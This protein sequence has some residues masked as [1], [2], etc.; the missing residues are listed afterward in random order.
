MHRL[1]LLV[2]ASV[3]HAQQAAPTIQLSPGDSTAI[4]SKVEQ[5]DAAVRAARSK[6]VSEDLIADVDVY[7][8]A[9]KWVLE[10]PE[11]LFV[12][13]DVKHTLAV[14]DTGIERAHELES[15]KSPWAEKKRKRVHGYYSALDGSVQPYAVTIPE[16]YDGTGMLNARSI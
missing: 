12:A 9:G 7:A 13:D 3:L 1:L 16:S 4:R 8:K 11:D 14:L 6:H 5:I 2:I 15:G 10:F